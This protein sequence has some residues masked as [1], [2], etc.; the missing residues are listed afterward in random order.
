MQWALSSHWD[1]FLSFGTKPVEYAVG[2][3][4]ECNG[5]KGSAWCVF[6]I[7][8]IGVHIGG[9]DYGKQGFTKNA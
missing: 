8:H 2:A 1:W 4:P 5:R 6:A 7:V 9:G 3:L